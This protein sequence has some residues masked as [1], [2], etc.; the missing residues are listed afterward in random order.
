MKALILLVC[1]ISSLWGACAETQPPQSLYKVLSWKNW[2]AT[3]SKQAVVT[4]PEDQPF[5]HLAREDQLDRILA[6]YWADTPQFVVLKVNP[7][8]LKGRL[9]YETNPGST[10]C[11]YHLYEGSIPVCAIVESRVI[12]RTPRECAK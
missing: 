12:D 8:Q 11:Y 10:T 5:I 7:A 3:Q 6:K 4:P 1:G 9:V 2:E